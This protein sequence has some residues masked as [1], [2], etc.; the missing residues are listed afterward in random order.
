MSQ[1]LKDLQAAKSAMRTIA[2]SSLESNEPERSF[3]SSLIWDRLATLKI[4]Q[5]AKKSRN[6]MVYIDFEHEVQTLRF[7]SRFLDV[8]QDQPASTSK[9]YREAMKYIGES[10]PDSSV[11]HSVYT[12][13]VPCCRG[14]EIIP[15]TIYSLDEL[16]TGAFGIKEPSLELQDDPLRHIPK[17]Q[18]GL[19]LV[20]GL[21][22]DVNG[23]RLGRGKGYYD[24]FLAQLEPETHLVALAF[25]CQIFESIPSG[26]QDRP[27]DVIITEDRVLGPWL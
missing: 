15:L 18:I 14:E 12:V 11:Y 16:K 3:K 17:D 21:A 6:I 13:V 23:H 8:P 26:P 19:V 25:E 10:V 24:R 9:P 5:Q 22:F 4:F 1:T 7:L 27:V 20:P 2:R